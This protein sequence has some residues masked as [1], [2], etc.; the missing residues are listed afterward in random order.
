MAEACVALLKRY[1]TPAQIS[2]GQFTYATAKSDADAVIA[3]L[4]TALDAG[5]SPVSLTSLQ[6]RLTNALSVLINFAAQSKAFFLRCL[7][8]AR[9]RKVWR[10]PIHHQG[11]DR[12]HPEGS[13]RW[14]ICPVQQPSHRC[15]SD[16]KKHPVRYE[17]AKWPNFADVPK[18]E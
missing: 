14:R 16:A 9:E 2:N 7:Q 15:G 5:N 8:P 4:G 3:G 12:S 13:H 11:I 6:S 18:A 17:S 10:L 1:G